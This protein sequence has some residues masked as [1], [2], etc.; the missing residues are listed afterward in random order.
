MRSRASSAR[1]ARTSRPVCGE[2]DGTGRFKAVIGAE[3]L[4]REAAAR[5]ESC[6]DAG[7]GEVDFRDAC[8]HLV[9]DDFDLGQP[10]VGVMEPAGDPQAVEKFGHA[11]DHELAAINDHRRVVLLVG[12]LGYVISAGRGESQREMRPSLERLMAPSRFASPAR[13]P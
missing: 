3:D 9:P 12:K 1:F 2:G 7:M 5:A 8:Q 10:L 13:A 11:I 6:F 4:D